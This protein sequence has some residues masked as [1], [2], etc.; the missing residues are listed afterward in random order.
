MR[1]F[2][3]ALLSFQGVAS[4]AVVDDPHAD[5]L[6]WQPTICRVEFYPRSD[7]TPDEN[8]SEVRKIYEMINENSNKITAGPVMNS[9]LHIF[10]SGDCEFLQVNMMFNSDLN[11]NLAT[12]D[13]DWPFD[14]NF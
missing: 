6:L 13:A 14:P 5:A 7:S 10:V 4:S 1:A 8:W 2:I 3:A 12:R 9:S 11:F